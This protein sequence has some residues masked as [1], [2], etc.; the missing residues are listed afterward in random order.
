MSKPMMSL[1][2]QIPMP[3][4]PWIAFIFDTMTTSKEAMIAFANESHDYMPRRHTYPN[5]SSDYEDFT[6]H[7]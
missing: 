1:I 2:H 5:Y 7:S 3:L 6:Q 4:A